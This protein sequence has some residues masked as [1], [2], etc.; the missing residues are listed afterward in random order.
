MIRRKWL[1]LWA[2]L[3]LI[4]LLLGLFFP[5]RFVSH[6]ESGKEG[7]GVVVYDRG[8]PIWGEFD[9]DRR[10]RPNLYSFFFF[11][12]ESVLDLSVDRNRRIIA[13]AV[14]CLDE[15]GKR[16][17]MYGDHTGSG[18]FTDRIIYGVDQP[19]KEILLPGSWKKLEKRGSLLGVTIDGQWHVVD[20]TNGAWIVS[21]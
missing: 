19:Y 4:L 5:Q 9:F 3:F 18:E 15:S 12:R 20:Y 21:D 17:I 7:T 16:K 13:S 1:Y 8:Q 6:T 14:T 2:A 11:S 10:G